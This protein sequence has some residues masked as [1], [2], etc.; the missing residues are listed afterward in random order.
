MELS[1]SIRSREENRMRGDRAGGTGEGEMLKKREKS[2]KGKE[3]PARR[4]VFFWFG[5]GSLDQEKRGEDTEVDEK[6]CGRLKKGK[7]EG[8]EITIGR[9][10]DS[11][12]F[13]P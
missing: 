2:A 6:I 8:K 3:G 7:R 5:H 9:R 10:P 11:N 1:L 12:T 4:G 13:E